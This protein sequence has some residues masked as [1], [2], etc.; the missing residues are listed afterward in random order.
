MTLAETASVMCEAI[1][2]EALLNQTNDSHEELVI[3]EGLLNRDAQIIVDIS[4]RYLFEKEVFERRAQSELSADELCEI[5]VRAQKA[6]YG[7]GLDERYLH[8]YM[9]TWKPHYYRASLSFYNFPYA[10][11]LLFATGLYAIYQQRGRPFI[12]DYKDLLASTGEASAADLAARFDIDIRSQKFWADSLA[13]S[14]Q[15][16][17]RYCELSRQSGI[18]TAAPRHCLE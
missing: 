18:T 13:V 11:G 3:L 4:S 12:E 9:W 7:D 1:L 6:T 14:G 10:F 15:R 5:M 8:K 16:I 2:M 17:D